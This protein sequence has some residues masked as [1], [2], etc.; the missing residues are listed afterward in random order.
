LYEHSFYYFKGEDEKQM[1][2]S[3]PKRFTNNIIFSSQKGIPIR[4]YPH[5]ASE[6]VNSEKAIL[7]HCPVTLVDEKKVTKGDPLLVVQYKEKK[8]TFVNEIKL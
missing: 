4:L 6:I 5:K 1:F 2:L 7:G 8:F 3:N